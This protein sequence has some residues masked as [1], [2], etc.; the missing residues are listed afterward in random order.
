MIEKEA[1]ANSYTASAG[2]WVDEDIDIPGTDEKGKAYVLLVGWTSVDAHKEFCE[3]QAFED[4]IQSIL[5]VKD[6]QKIEAVHSSLTK[7]AASAS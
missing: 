4:N 5:G 7:V 6:L 3:T 2:G 1:K